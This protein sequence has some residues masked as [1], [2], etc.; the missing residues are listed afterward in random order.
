MHPGNA[1]DSNYCLKLLLESSRS[2]GLVAS[3]GCCTCCWCSGWCLARHCSFC[4]LPARAQITGEMVYS[5]LIESTTV[6]VLEQSEKL[7]TY[8]LKYVRV[9]GQTDMLCPFSCNSRAERTIP[10]TKHSP[11]YLCA[12]TTLVFALLMWRPQS[13]E[14]FV[15]GLCLLYCFVL[16]SA[17]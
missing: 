16:I 15:Q 17:I 7:S 2:K 4:F 5:L 1:M 9:R 3:S 8:V 11:G 12:M 14:L 10:S 13:W 6:F